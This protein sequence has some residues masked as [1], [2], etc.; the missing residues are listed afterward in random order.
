MNKSK[1]NY[2][3]LNLALEIKFRTSQVTQW[4]KK[5]PAMQETQET[6]VVPGLGRSPGGGHGNPLQY[7]C[8]EGPM[9]RGV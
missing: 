9:D 8:L 2:V 4:V 1:F 6:Q 5:Q 7:R 3:T